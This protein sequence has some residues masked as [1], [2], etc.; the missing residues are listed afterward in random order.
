MRSEKLG[1]LKIITSHFY[2]ENEIGERRMA[3]K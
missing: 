3:S 1:V 2:S